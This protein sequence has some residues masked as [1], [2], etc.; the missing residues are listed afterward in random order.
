MQWLY[1]DFRYALRESG[2][3]PGF[4][5]LAI[6]TLAMGIGAVTT[7]YSV[8]H[9]VL[10]NPFPYSDPRR[11]VDVVVQDT[12]REQVR[13]GA[14]SIPEFRAYVDNSDVFEE[15][16]GEDPTQM[17]YRAPYGSEEFGVV[18]VTPNTFHFLGV[19]PLIG[20]AANAEDAN[21][22]APPVAV[23][24]HKTWMKYFGADPSVIGRKI[25]LNDKS[26]NVIGVM[27]PHF[28]WNNADVWIPDAASLSDPDGK[29]KGFW[30]QARLKHNITIA[31]AEAR[32]NIIGRQLALRYPER[33]PKQ[34]R[35][36][37]ITVIDWVIGKFRL[38]LYTLFGAVGL[39]LLIA[40]CNVANMLLARATARE[41]EIAIRSA[42]GA[43]RFQILR[44][45]LVESMLLA[46]GGGVLGAGLAY[47]GVKV[48]VHFIP[49][50]TL[51][52]ET[53]IAIK[54]PVLFFCLAIALFTALL[55]GVVPAL[56]ATRR[57]LVPGLASSGKGAGGGV[58]RG[59]LR[60]SLV[61]A[62]VALSLVLLTGAGV[63]MRSFFAEMSVDLGFNP[64]NLV[65]L[66]ILL[67]NVT[68]AQ[69]HQFFRAAAVKLQALPGVSSA[70]VTSG[71]PPYDAFSTT[72]VVPGQTN[73]ER[74]VGSF[75]LC[76]EDYFRVVGFRLLKGALFTPLDVSTANKVA[77]VNETLSRRY[78]A[79]R[80]PIGRRITLTRLH[81]T[82][83]V[84]PDPT[85]TIV[86]V[87]SD[88]KNN[89]PQETTEAEAFVPFTV[90]G[91]G[92]PNLLVRTSSEGTRMVNALWREIRALNGSAIQYKA[93]TVESMLFDFSY[94][95]SQFS[96]L[97]LSVFASI[98]L[99]LV[100]SGVYG[101]L[102][103][104][105]SQQ[106]REI[107][108]RMALGAQRGDVL[109][110]V[111]RMTLQL[112]VAGVIIGAIASLAA[113]RLVSSYI[114]RVPTFDPLTLIGAVLTIVILG[115][116]ASF[117]PARRATQIDPLNALHDE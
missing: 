113:N 99:V 14:L 96:V 78:F 117:L 39:L 48:L 66:E 7:M 75:D 100:G 32:L 87:V 73:S 64:H 98:G 110:S 46:I 65:L 77:V 6:C 80:D 70:S 41:R 22:G 34:F 1:R 109:Q 56:Y 67:P 26:M 94:A 53:E 17:V 116:A 62:E 95:R 21:A 23:L 85:F 69:K 104:S 8:I 30:L 42:V 12:E 2:R 63:L 49:P 106:T 43:T 16:V 19:P 108:I 84:T 88:A 29:S 91:L 5:L 114:A 37:V 76:S 89:G 61:V 79:G 45:L 13:G 27:P 97:L 74:Q 9:N 3:R 115:F 101:V 25:V 31:Q 55:F 81:Q 54:L 105:V 10:L 59:K 20:R 57:D 35:I 36:K 38:V 4:L 40:C 68:N 50:Y 82:P 52:E 83:D 51:A 58:G 86:G 71:A 47:G 28:A 111:L 93:R 33:Y 11:M 15:A 60:S 90:S 72:I 112:T 103:Y 44:Q 92:Y 107:G 24:S 18:L 102:A